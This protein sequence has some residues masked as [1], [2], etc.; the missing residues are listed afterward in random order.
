M[1]TFCTTENNFF[2]MGENPASSVALRGTTFVLQSTN[3]VL[4]G[5]LER[6]HRLYYYNCYYNY[7]YYY[8][9]YYY[10]YY[11]YYHYYHYYYY[12]HASLR[13]S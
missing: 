8:Y 5:R 1:N 11:H 13:M 6:E 3:V 4:Q 10:N 2:I 7:Y 12:S 9:Y